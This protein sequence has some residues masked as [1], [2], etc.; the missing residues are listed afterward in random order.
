MSMACVSRFA[1]IALV[2]LAAGCRRDHDPNEPPIVEAVAPSFGPAAGGVA[3]TVWGHDFDPG[4]TVT[5]GGQGASSVV[6]V[7]PRTITAVTP[8][9][10][11]SAGTVDV[12]VINAD[13]QGH[14]LTGGFTVTSG[15]PPPPPGSPLISGVTPNWGTNAGGTAI[16]ITGSAFVNGATV[17]IGG[18]AATS[19]TFVNATSLTAVTPSVA[20][21][22]GPQT[23]TVTN[24]DTLSGSLSSAFNAATSGFLDGTFG[25]SGVQLSDPSGGAD[26][27]RAARIEG[28]SLIVF[29]EDLAAGGG[30]WRIESRN[31]GT[32]ALDAGFGTSGVVQSNP[33]ANADAAAAFTSDGTDLFLLG[34]NAGGANDAWRIESR[35][36]ATGAL[37]TGFGTNGVLA[38]DPST[39]AD[40]PGDILVLGTGLFIAGADT[41]PG[42][43]QWRVE[44]RRLNN[45]N[46][47]NTFGTSGVLV[48][49]PGTAADLPAVVVTDG[50][51]LFLIGSVRDST[52]PNDARWRIEKRAAGDGALVT[53]FGT[54]GAVVSDPSS[55]PDEPWAAVVAGGDLYVIGTDASNGTTDLAW[56]I[57]R[58]NASTGALITAFG[59]GG[60]IVSNPSAGLDA[61][62]AV[63]SDGT[64]LFVAGYDEVA[65][66]ADRRWRIERRSLTS[67]ALVT[68]FAAQGVLTMNPTANHDIATA[69]V[70][71][72]THVYVVGVDAGTGNDRWR[73]EKRTK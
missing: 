27:P 66:A 12:R 33:S 47:H 53:A 26:T 67:G 1:L 70:A 43:D 21:A 7:D 5:I 71:D 62:F 11:P 3:I 45:G 60:V 34:V 46:V 63:A 31:T 38:V 54:S 48:T 18:L 9:L 49:N 51:D 72:S 17:T 40:P 13:G 69:I 8:A 16:T 28:S 73:L 42:N 37:N 15:G 25:T 41:T 22:T 36:I 20:P 59:T 57:E 4:A 50:T 68:T 14:T 19:V 23:V 61:P 58:R 35:T 39:G 52:A 2:L 32:A 6:V 30:Q 64:D 56:R 55:G 29:G 24:P 44:K 10:N 65:G